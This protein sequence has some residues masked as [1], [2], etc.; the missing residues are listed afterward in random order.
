VRFARTVFVRRVALPA[1]R[2]A[3]VALLTR[4]ELQSLGACFDRAWPVVETP[5]LNGLLDAIDEADRKFRQERDHERDAGF[6]R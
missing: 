5:G 1:Q 3:A 6:A 4:P 2:I